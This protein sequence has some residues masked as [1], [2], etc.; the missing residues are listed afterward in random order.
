[1]FRI[2]Q[3]IG[4]VTFCPLFCFFS[5][6]GGMAIAQNQIPAKLTNTVFIE[7]L[8]AD[9]SY[10][11]QKNALTAKYSK[12]RSGRWGEFVKGVCE[13]LKTDKKIV[14]FTFDACG[15]EKGTDY[16]KELID[17]IR[18]E[19][20]PATI[21]VTGRWIDNH[22]SEFLNLAGDT[23]FE[24]ENHG[25]NHRPCSVSGKSVYGIRGTANAA[26]AFDEVEGNALKIE[27][28]TG[29][30]PNFYR[31][32]TAFIDE[33]GAS[34]VRDLSITPISYQVLSGDA[35]PTVSKNSIVKNVLDTV[36]PGAVII[37]HM[38]H[39]QWQTFEALQKIVPELRKNGY[40]FAH[41]NQYKL[42]DRRGN[43]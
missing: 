28:I 39:P 12:N 17:F 18:K 40:R 7:H 21:F 20:I 33:P 43:N 2:N 27:A 16:D 14:A 31:S 10:I 32:A 8:N 4:I 3:F 24:I 11:R 35:S 34:M 42:I 13:D 37:M 22:Y 19:R 25:L 6:I 30:R 29:R 9:P 38:N 41:L 26:E 1:M 5:L 23:L 15:G 36:R